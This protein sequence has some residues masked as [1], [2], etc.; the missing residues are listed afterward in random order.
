MQW[1]MS[2]KWLPNL[3]AFLVAVLLAASISYWVLQWPQAPMAPVGTDASGSTELAP[4]DVAAIGRLL[5]ASATAEPV[6]E[7]A[8]QV[9]LRLLGTVARRDGAGAAIVSV[10]G[11]PARTYIV[12]ATLANGLV[13]QSVERGKASF[14]ASPAGPVVQTLELPPPRAGN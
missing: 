13:L 12:G 3:G 11:K 8:A 14:S 6:V 5:G 9:N 7:A 4:P 1:N 2:D 10:D